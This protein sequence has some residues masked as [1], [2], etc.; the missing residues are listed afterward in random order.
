[1]S[2][3]ASWFGG[4]ALGRR[5]HGLERREQDLV[6]AGAI[7]LGVTVLYFAV[8][9]PVSDWSAH[10]EA[11]YARQLAIVDYLRTNEAAARSAGSASSAQQTGGGS[12]LTV[13][14]DTAAA[15]GVA[16]TRYQNE[17]GGGL[18]I[19]LQDQ[20]FDSVLRWLAQLERAEGRRI[21]QLSVDAQG[22]PGRVNARISVL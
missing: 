13:V 10:A 3:L 12:I 8:W 20:E 11:Q 17:T 19:V 6:T 21:R 4:S 2:R 14:A 18:S 22:N 16:L 9:Q 15:A 1:M 7:V 5:F